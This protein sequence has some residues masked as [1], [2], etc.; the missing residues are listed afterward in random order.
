[1]EYPSIPTQ[2][3]TNSR[4]SS[5]SLR[6]EGLKICND[7]EWLSPRL[8]GEKQLKAADEETVVLLKRFSDNPHIEKARADFEQ[9]QKLEETFHKILMGSIFTSRSTGGSRLACE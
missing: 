9:A 5:R 4:R 3:E 7:A 6:N 1:M 8:A 2:S